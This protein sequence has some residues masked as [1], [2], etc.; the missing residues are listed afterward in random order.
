MYNVKV[1]LECGCF[2]RSGYSANN[3]F[4]TKEEALKDATKMVEDMNKNFCGKHI[5]SL[6]EEGNDI[7]I[8]VKAA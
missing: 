7:I 8:D 6:Q 1:N 3:S 2:K 4:D 5:F